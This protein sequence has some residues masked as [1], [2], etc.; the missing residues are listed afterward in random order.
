MAL[1]AVKQNGIAP[2]YAPWELKAD[3]KVVLEAAKQYGL[4]LQYASLA[5]RNGG[6]KTYVAD[7]RV[8]YSTPVTTFLLF[9]SA[10]SAITIDSLR[11][12]ATCLTRTRPAPRV[13]EAAC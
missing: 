1:E 10:S 7:L 4:A 11:D 13:V 12:D 5:L 8:A 2:Y 3:K 6:L 9:A